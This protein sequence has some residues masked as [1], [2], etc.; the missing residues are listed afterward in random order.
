M[1]K[2]QMANGR[3]TQS[4]TALAIIGIFMCNGG[5][6]GPAGTRSKYGPVIQLIHTYSVSARITRAQCR[7]DLNRLA[8]GL[9]LGS[10][11]GRSAE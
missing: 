11:F 5:S 10:E 7:P 3:P 4:T 2:N 1:K 6:F 8:L 9:N